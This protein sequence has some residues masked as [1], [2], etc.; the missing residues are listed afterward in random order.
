MKK[1]LRFCFIGD[2]GVGKSCLIATAATEVFPSNPP[3]VLPPI[4]LPP[5]YWKEPSP[6]QL[7]DTSSS[8]QDKDLVDS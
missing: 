6:I 7:L 8:P 1:L 4:N 2:Q 5:D 3:P